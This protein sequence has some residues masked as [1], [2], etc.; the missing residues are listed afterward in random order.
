MKNK[1]EYE[2]KKLPKKRNYDEQVISVLDKSILYKTKNVKTNKEKLKEIK[3]KNLEI[4]KKLN[5][6]NKN[7]KIKIENNIKTENKNNINSQMVVAF[8]K[9]KVNLKELPKIDLKKI[10]IKDFKF[11]FILLI[12]IFIVILLVGLI[13]KENKE[14]RQLAQANFIKFEQNNK[15][16][17]IDEI[18]EKNI[19]VTKEKELIVEQV[20]INYMTINLEN[21]NLPKDERVVVQEGKNGRQ[22]ITKVVIYENNEIVEENIIN[23]EIY[24]D[25][26]QE[27]IEIGTSET[28]RDLNIH[29]GDYVIVTDEVEL[30]E[31]PDDGIT[32]IKIPKYYDVKL[33]EI[34]DNW[35]KV[36][37][38]NNIGYI[39]NTKYTTEAVT[40]GINDKSRIAKIKGNVNLEMDLTQKSGLTLNDYKKILKNNNSDKNKIF[41]NNYE[42]FYNIEQKYNINGV[43]LASIAIHESGWGTS[44]IAVEKKN[45]FGF[46]SYDSSPYESSYT[47]DTYEEGL[48]VVAKSLIKNYLNPSGTVIFE[49]ELAT[50]V[51]YNGPT[52]PGVN[53]RYASDQNWNIKVFSKMLYLYNKL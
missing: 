18:L 15:K 33:L 51:Y 12:C 2:I 35:S 4:R 14:I 29:I 21:P 26:V 47:F 44:R 48:E 41:E 30:K 3:K 38:E 13:F 8:N 50:G 32:I 37:F 52:L 40:F 53:V 1:T 24:E 22:E 45:L 17:D 9:K 7:I 46:G 42:A 34:I 28:L 49:G 23:T 19:S 20:D 10:K 31:K 5:S 27:I 25:S 39:K 16:I 6:K 36:E 43:F 11:L